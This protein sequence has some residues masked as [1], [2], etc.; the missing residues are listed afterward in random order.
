M[1]LYAYS[2]IR[3]NGKLYNSFSTLVLR[4]LSLASRAI[5]SAVMT[6]SLPLSW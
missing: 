4:T 2:Q 6:H 5:E 3:L 1:E